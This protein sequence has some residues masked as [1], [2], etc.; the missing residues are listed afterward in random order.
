MSRIHHHVIA[1]LGLIAFGCTED[2][3][4]NDIKTSGI[5][6]DMEVL[7]TG[8]GRST[9]TVALKPGGSRSNTYLEMEGEDELVA[10]VDDEDRR[11]G[12]SGNYYKATFD[13]EAGDTEF[14]VSF[15]RA[16]EDVSAPDSNVTL[17]DPF[18]LEGIPDSV[19][20]AE[21]IEVTWSPTSDDEEW[22]LDGDCMFPNGSDVDESGT[23]SLSA[24]DYDLHDDE[25][26]ETC[27][28]TLCVERTRRGEVDPA[29]GEGGVFVAIQRR[30][31]S[32][33]STP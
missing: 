22:E 4:S 24:N 8:N 23:L 9:V 13:T 15:N 29:F 2:V 7:A 12:K 30:C 32:F 20:R 14:V 10:A 1:V 3:D 11:L 31:V 16:D 6:A 28:A 19:S 26:E 21:E 25:D 5:Y 33:T 27:E 18:E 17:P